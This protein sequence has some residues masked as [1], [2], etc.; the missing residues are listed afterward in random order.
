V[1]P[2][3]VEPLEETPREDDKPPK[4]IVYTHPER[5]IEN[6][7]PDDKIN[8]I[9]FSTL[10]SLSFFENVLPKTKFIK[11]VNQNNEKYDLLSYN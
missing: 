1:I 5:N 6:L 4:E 7:K 3:D 8:F 10:N 11:Q 9:N 2:E